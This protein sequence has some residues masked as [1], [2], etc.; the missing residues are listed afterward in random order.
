MTDTTALDARYAE[1]MAEHG[2]LL[3]ELPAMEPLMAARAVSLLAD[4]IDALT[5]EYEA[6]L[7][8]ARDQTEQP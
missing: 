1:L 2:R 3:D 8:A 6:T 7:C 4:R 5:L